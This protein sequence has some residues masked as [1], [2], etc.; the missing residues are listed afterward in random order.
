M[1]RC[2]CGFTLCIA[3]LLLQAPVARAAPLGKD[4]CAKLKVE[5]GE[6][7]KTGTRGNMG[8]G[9]QWAKTNLAPDQLDQVRRLLEVDEQLLFRCHGRPLVNLPKDPD[10]DPAA[11]EPAAKNGGKAAKAPSAEKKKALKKAAAPP[12]DAAAKG[13][14]KQEPG[15]DA[16]AKDAVKQEPAAGAPPAEAPAAATPEKKTAQKPTA[17]KKT[18]SKPKAD[19]A[20]R[21][22]TGEPGADPFARQAPPKQ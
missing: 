8:K 9:P 18:K 5:Q 3:A 12:A 7:E 2:R 6:L 10:P 4:G 14:A 17:A 22:P 20:F 19:D 13:A 16:A 11:R 15:A 1:T 21:A